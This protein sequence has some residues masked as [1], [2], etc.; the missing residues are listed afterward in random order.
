M[1]SEIELIGDDN[2]YAVIGDQSAVERF[3]NAQGLASKDLGL[4]RLS[5]ALG[6]AAATVQAGAEI[7]ANS[8]RWVKLTKESAQALNQFTA[9]KGS[10]AHLSRA[11]V[12]ENGKIKGILQFVKGSGVSLTNPA[13]LAGAAGIMAQIAMQQ[14]M[15]EITDYLAVIDAKV[16]DLLRGQRD[17]VLADMIGVDLMIEEAMTIREHSGRVSETGWSKIQ[18][19]SGIVARTQ[20]YAL[21]QLDAI[22]E[23]LERERDVDDLAVLAKTA[24][25]SVGDWLAVLARCFQLQDG[26]AILELERVLDASPAE[27]DS[28]RV[29]LQ[30]ARQNRLNRIAKTTES[31]LARINAAAAI[32]NG[33]V[34]LNPFSG[35]K[36][37]RSSNHVSAGIVEFEGRLGIES[38][39][40]ALQAKRWGEAA[41]D[42]RDSALET[43]AAGV[44]AA[45][46]LGNEGVDRARVAAGTL[47]GGMSER[48][49]RRRGGEETKLDRGAQSTDDSGPVWTNSRNVEPSARE[50]L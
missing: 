9:M 49:L 36:V 26:I 28:H 7:A 15:N 47:L 10:A 44:G 24:E 27:L 18:N 32:A 21:L 48:M 50:Q 43:G 4:Q 40:E 20:A 41:A 1:S 25:T 14:A 30:A 16:D 33:K 46:R 38:D 35:R 22:A 17:S 42:V 34:L 29:G 5:P 11:V 45:V 37:V 2:G 3:L 6:T 23:K 31:L 13:M 8:G 12:T 19:S 39:H